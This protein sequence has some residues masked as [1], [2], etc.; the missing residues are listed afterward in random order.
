MRGHSGP[1]FLP[2]F[3]VDLPVPDLRPWLEGNSLPGVWS[4]DAPRPGPHVALVAL[5]HGNE[6]AGGLLLA[7]WLAEGLRPARGRLT[8]VFANLA[9]FAR[10]DPADPT[11]SRFVDEDLNRVWCETVLDGPRRSAELDRAR[12]LRPLLGTV[13][14]LLDLHSMLWPSDPLILAGAGPR[15]RRLARRLGVPPLVVADQAGH[16]SGRRLIDHSAFTAPEGQRTALLVEAGQHWQPETLAVMEACA[17]ALL[18]ETGMVATPPPPRPP[19]RVAEVTRTVVA[20]THG[21]AFVE[22]FRGGA[23]IPAR[24]TLLALDGEAEIRTPHDDCLLVMPSPR[25]LR[26]HT[27]VRLARFLEEREI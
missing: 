6:I 2:Y 3:P 9:A 21:F 16:A 1:A 7:R 17:T 24:N 11:L 13:D 15:A 10:F 20:G 8:F 14:V 25:T 26:G 27:A 4:F 5:I 23:I 12:E 18:A 19:G 22:P